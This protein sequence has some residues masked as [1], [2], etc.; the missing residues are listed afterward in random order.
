[1]TRTTPQ[2]LSTNAPHA[3][4][5]PDE[6]DTDAWSE[7]RRLPFNTDSPTWLQKRLERPEAEER[8][9][10][11]VK[12]LESEVIPRLVE[13]HRATPMCELLPAAPVSLLPT[14]AEVDEFVQLLLHRDD[15]SISTFVMTLRRRGMS[16]E[17]LFLELLATAANQL[18]SL[19]EEDSCDFTDVTIAVGRLQQ[20]LQVLSPLWDAEAE[21]P[22]N[23]RRVLLVPAPGEQHTFGLSMV[24]E[25]FVH[26]GWEVAGGRGAYRDEA[27]DMV[28]REWFDVIGFSVGGDARL[29]WLTTCIASVRQ[30][31]RNPDIGI[32]VGGPVFKVHPEYVAVVGADATS[33]DGKQAPAAAEGLIA[34]RVPS[35]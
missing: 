12:T 5:V 35:R 30:R 13:A 1:M 15:V 8:M 26:A 29:D 7:V 6:A 21:L 28:S 27:V 18:G 9:S 23:A 24:A 16:V 17:V 11:L 3:A 25:F 32:L 4:A 31:S 34:N 10:R 2:A 33:Q 14:P 20:L 19:W 22:A